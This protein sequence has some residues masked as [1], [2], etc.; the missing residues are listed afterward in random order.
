[1]A[2]VRAEQANRE[3]KQ[4]REQAYRALATLI[5]AEGGLLARPGDAST[6][7]V[8]TE[9]E[10][11]LRLRP[12]FRALNSAVLSAR[13]YGRAYAWRWA[14]SLSLFGN[15]R[16]FNYDNF[17]RQNHAWA[18]GGQLDW[19]L[20]DGGTRDAQR[21]A[22][23]ALAEESDARAAAMADTVRDELANAR[24]TL[25]TKQSAHAAAERQ[26]DLARETLDLVRTQ[27]EAGHTAQ[28]DLLQAQDSLVAAREAVAQA[29]LELALA[30]LSLRRAAGTFPGR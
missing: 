22:A 20:Y 5:Q 24:G 17:A 10:A 19:V 25:G 28:I 16:V 3:A 30:D 2:L 6:M 13:A 23:R 15:A 11:A 7:S 1:M 18:V 4:G 29:H 21:H 8:S 27:Y 12:E 9:V 26:V 14:P